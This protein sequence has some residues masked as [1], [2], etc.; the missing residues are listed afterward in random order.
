MKH[1]PVISLLFSL[2]FSL[3]AFSQQSRFEGYVYDGDTRS[4]LGFATVQIKHTGEGTTTNSDGRF[5]LEL[6]AGTHD[7]SVSFVGYESFSGSVTVPAGTPVRFYLKPYS[8]VMPE[9]VIGSGMEDPAYRI[10]RE[11]IKRKASNKQ[12]LNSF[13]YD[14]YTK[15]IFTSAGQI[16]MIEESFLKGFEEVHK[17]S[18]EFILANYKT[19]NMK[20]RSSNVSMKDMK[21][22][23]LDLSGETNMLLGN[24]VQLPLS[25][26]A[27]GYY[28]YRLLGTTGTGSDL[29]YII[30]VIPDSKIHP[31][32]KGKIYI[33]GNNYA[34]TGAELTNNEGLTM[35]YFKGVA[36]NYTQKMNRFGGYWLPQLSHYKVEGEFDFGGLLALDKMEFEQVVSVSSYKINSSFPD[37]VEKMKV[38]AANPFYMNDSVM[39]DSLRTASLI[40]GKAYDMQQ[41]TIDSLRPVPLS[42]SETRAFAELDSTKRIKNFIKPKG[43]LAGLA[44]VEDGG[45]R[46]PEKKDITGYLF[47]YLKYDNTRAGGISL[48]GRYQYDSRRLNFG[49]SAGYLFGLKTAEYDA[50]ALYRVGESR[51]DCFILEYFNH[52]R[53][54]EE[55]HQFPGIV[56]AAAVTFGLEDNQ[57]YMW[58]QGYSLGFKKQ[59]SDVIAARIDVISE[60]DTSLTKLYRQRIFNTPGRASRINPKI[61]EGY[62]NRLALSVTAGSDPY[63]YQFM[64]ED[65]LF[66]RGEF[67]SDKLKSDFRYSYFRAAGQLKIKTIFR[68]L[69]FSPYLL[70][71]GEGGL[72]NGSYGPQHLMTPETSLEIVSGFGVFKGIKPYEFAGSRMAALHME[73]NWRTVIFQ[74]LGL[75]WLRDQNINVLTGASALKM[76]NGSG[77]LNKN[78][79]LYYEAYLGLSGILGMLRTDAVYTSQERFVMRLSASLAL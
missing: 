49:L 23:L 11:A 56:N 78:E 13:E 34:L 55:K 48:G 7:I 35:P 5:I 70:I 16:A 32:L 79:K 17:W 30:D 62:D 50:Y 20:A 45:D 36:V 42:A 14:A 1:F 51:R 77:Y 71:R 10:I 26:D 69:L 73:H 28:R 33:E 41:Q 18:R 12:G 75:N 59:I 40:S 9:I 54:W 21:F 64:P 65:G 58:A 60:K 72:V 15:K 63:D 39:T 24:R 47:K 74:S 57:N 37:S 53:T 52:I 31:L 22:G 2:L 38:Y 4:P 61:T 6:P 46:E 25:S 29:V 8:I 66:F 76:W 3:P 67:S 19:E 44:K 68:G 43:A 27:F